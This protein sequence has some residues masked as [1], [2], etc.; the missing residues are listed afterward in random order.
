M[1]IRS[2]K[3]IQRNENPSKGIVTVKVILIGALKR[4]NDI[5]FYKTAE[6]TGASK[7]IDMG[8]KF[9]LGERLGIDLEGEAKGTLSG[10]SWKK[11]KIG[12]A[13][14]LG[15]TYHLGIGQGYLLTTPLQVNFWTTVFANEGIL[16]KPHL[17][18]GKKEILNKDFLNKENID[19]VREGMKESCA[20]GGVAWPFFDFKVANSNLKIDDMN[21]FQ[22]ASDGAKMVRVAVGCKT[23]TAETYENEDPH[24][25]I[26]VFAPYYNPEIVV[27][28]LVENGGEGSNV[29]APIAKK[30][31]E[32]YFKN[33]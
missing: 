4:S 13:W 3:L 24:A 14:Y 11:E 31:L 9:F 2:E 20:T 27:T 15:D 21:Y 32:T 5:F 33:K 1:A 19:L 10:P 25:W 30:I 17:I 12:E 16:Y 22:S 23:G 8:K 28:V 29:A 26:T 7:I 6:L 18:S